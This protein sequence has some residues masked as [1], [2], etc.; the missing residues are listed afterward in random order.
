MKRVIIIFLTSL[1]LAATLNAK[2]IGPNSFYKTIKSHKLVLVKFWASWCIPC[3]ILKP[4]FNRA[5][6][7]LGKRAL[8]VEYNVD[9]GGSPLRKYNI[10]LIPTMV[11][12][13]NG[14][15]VSS[16]SS[17]LSSDDIVNWVLK[18]K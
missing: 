5:K 8:L 3:S 14:K 18:Y 12:F 1:L 16:Y 15:E 2:A 4:E 9:L 11:L 10:H 17:V 6:K 7:I 13:K